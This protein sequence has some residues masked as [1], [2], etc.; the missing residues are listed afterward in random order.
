MS[1]YPELAGL[2]LALILSSVTIACGLGVC[3]VVAVTKSLDSKG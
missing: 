3:A 1:M 2:A